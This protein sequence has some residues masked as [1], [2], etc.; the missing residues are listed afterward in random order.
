M[1]VASPG[2]YHQH[3]GQWNGRVIQF[4]RLTKSIGGTRVVE[5]FAIGFPSVGRL[6]ITSVESEPKGQST[7]RLVGTRAVEVK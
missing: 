2:L 6:T 1:E 5:D 3:E 4:E 7:L